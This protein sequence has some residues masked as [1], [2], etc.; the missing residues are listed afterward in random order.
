MNEN[1]TRHPSIASMLGIEDETDLGIKIGLLFRT[2]YGD[3]PCRVDDTVVKA[4]FTSFFICSNEDTDSRDPGDDL[5]IN[6][7]SANP[8]YDTVPEHLENLSRSK[9]NSANF[10]SSSHQQLENSVAWLNQSALDCWTSSASG[11]ST[12]VSSGSNTIVR[13]SISSRSE[14]LD[15]D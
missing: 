7:P 15:P 12:K 11:N 8:D 6:M 9:Q 5:S 3:R 2:K 13:M 1:L 10:S 4:T 14:L